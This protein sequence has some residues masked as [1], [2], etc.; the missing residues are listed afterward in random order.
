MGIVKV[1]DF[2]EKLPLLN[3]WFLSFPKIMLFSGHILLWATL[4]MLQRCY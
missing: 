3:Y 1:N 4:L 2:M